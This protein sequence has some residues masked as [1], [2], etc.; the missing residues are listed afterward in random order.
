MAELLVDILQYLTE[1][2][3]AVAA[4]APADML[5]PATV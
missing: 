3:A 2:V 4:P 5:D 1:L